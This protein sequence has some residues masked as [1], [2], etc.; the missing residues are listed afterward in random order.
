MFYI[1][2]SSDIWFGLSFN[3][4]I[5]I[6][7]F[8]T[9]DQTAVSWGTIDQNKNVQSTTLTY[10]NSLNQP[11]SYSYNQLISPFTIYKNADILLQLPNDLSSIGI[12]SGSY[13][14]SYNFV[15]EMA[16]SPT[17]PLTIKEI[18]NS[19]TEIKLIPSGQPDIEYNAFCV[20]KFPISDVAPVLISIAKD[21]PYDTIYKEMS[22]LSKYQDGISFLKF[23]FF[24][25]DDGSV[26]NLLKNM[27]QDFVSYSSTSTSATTKGALTRIQGITTYYTNFIL[28]NY[29]TIANF[30]DIQQ[31]FINFVNVRLDQQFIQLL[32]SEDQGYL[33]ARQFCYDFFVVYFY[34]NATN[35]LQSSY[36]NKYFG[37]F[38]NVLNFG[39]NQYYPI[40]ANNYLDERETIDDPITLIIKLSSAL[41]SDI[42]EKDSCWVSNFGMAPYVFTSII[43]TTPQ[44]QTYT[45]APPNFGPPQKLINKSNS[46]VLYS[47]NDLTGSYTTNNDVR[48]NQT[49][50][51]LNTD[52]SNFNNFVVFSSA[53]VRLSIFKNKMIQ[54]TSLS[55]SI[56]ALNTTYQNSLTSSTPYQYYFTE[57]AVLTQKITTLVNSFDAYESYLF[58]NGNY[59]F[60]ITNG[61]FYSASYVSSQDFTASLYD[62]NNRDSLASNVPDYVKN[63]SQDYSDYLTFLNMMG[64]HFDDIYVYISAM[65]IERQVRNQLSSS[66]PNNTLKEMLYSFGWDVDDI[67]GDL[68]MTDVYLNSMNSASYNVLSG[69][70]RLQTIWNRLLVTLPGI[71]KTKGTTEC[72]NYLMA[73]YGLPT[74]LITIREYGGTDFS[75]DNKPTY[76]LDEKTYMLKFS[77]IGDYVEG[78]IPYSTNTVEFKFSID[79][80]PFRTIYPDFKFFPLFTSIPH[81]YTSTTNFN[82]MVGFYRVPGTS[83][84]KVVFQMG[85]GS[86]GTFITSST[87][88]IFNGDI[89]SVMVRRN[90]QFELFESPSGSLDINNVIPLEYDLYVQRNEEGNRIF[91]STSSVNLYE[92]DNDVF[93]QFGRFRLT[94][95]NFKGTL[96]KLSIWDVTITDGDFEEHVND[97]NSYGY[98]GSLPYQDLWVR[99]NWDYPQNMYSIYSS[100]VWITNA[101]PYFAIPNYYTDET[102]TTIN[103]ATYSASLGIITQ[104]W[105]AYYPTGSVEIRAYNFPEAID[106]AFSASFISCSWFSQSVYPYHFEELTYEQNIDASKYGPTKYKNVKIGTI[107]YEI[108][109]RFDPIDRSTFDPSVT[110]SG[111]SNQLGFFID[112][113]D[114][115]NKDIIRYVGKTGIMDLI[116]DPSNLYSDR[117]Y[118]LRNKNAEYNSTGDKR[119]L[120]EELLTMYKFYFDKSIFQAILNVLPARANAYTGVIIEPTLL[121]RP[122]YQNRPISSSASPS[123][124]NPAIVEDIYKFSETLLWANFNTNF[125]QVNTGVNS[126]SLQQT[127]TQSLP[128][129]YTQII[130][131]NVNEP[132]RMWPRNFGNGY[133]TDFMDNIQH[134]FYPDLE[135]TLRLWETSSTGPLPASCSVPIKGTVSHEDQNGRLIIGPDHGVYDTTKYFSGFNQ[136]NHPIV[137]YMVK[138]WD[139][140]KYY[141]KTGEYVHDDNPLDNAYESCSVYLYKYAIFDEYFMRTQIYFTDL[142][143][144]SMYNPNDVSYHYN[145]TIPAYLHRANTFI[146]TP[147]Q[148]VSNINAYDVTFY[149]NIG[150]LG[151]ISGSMYFELV[152]G[153]PRNHYTH[154]MQQFSKKKYGTSSGTLF[155][156]GQQTI[157]S[158]IN[159]NGIDDGTNPVQSF[160]TSNVKVVNSTSVIQSVPSSAAGQVTPS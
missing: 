86:S 30:D 83:T 10:L 32:G 59:Q 38:K 148:K 50:A 129:S 105:L 72:V 77:G 65:P 67:I 12:T 126:A 7:A 37:Y 62:S 47:S 96:D 120:F 80:D 123:Y 90:E 127:M 156:K 4:A 44:Y 91:Y 143:Y 112:P 49:I 55:A 95:G 145:A 152:S 23:A 6:S 104:S 119:T 26:I 15:R 9:D 3:D 68:D 54:W 40:L 128:P 34:E 28:Q 147:D 75:E 97:L 140:Y 107:D 16:G 79:D 74:S 24:L 29:G 114:S 131:L 111:Q 11:I 110:V 53:A 42:N 109:T 63:T 87:L 82:W 153:Y 89:F 94:N 135:N 8:T 85:S 121:E 102:L 19:R 159:E 36:E 154:K 101:S 130:D 155:I 84:G 115:K 125:S 117:Y 116:G 18:S 58:S 66:I 21:I 57:N 151:M 73:C 22:S 138:V 17:S 100:S 124:K 14:I 133:I 52:Y 144:L 41:P 132:T 88:P 160:D 136:G 139:K 60:N 2:Q 13:E 31:Q 61:S 35:P 134:S 141:A 146:G 48:I 46:N 99:L 70:Q 33:D 51:E 106:S 39:N 142:G 81:P 158:T 149:T 25:T 150:S 157:N 5:E 113:Q 45:I 20:G 43:Q 78:P 64:H 56:S 137:Y 92:N 1:S 27:Y 98:S 71:Y 76:Q 69:Q 118:D 103:P 108:D 93:S 122:K